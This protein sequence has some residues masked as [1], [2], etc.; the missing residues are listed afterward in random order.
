MV[1]YRWFNSVLSFDRAPYYVTHIR[2]LVAFEEG[3]GGMLYTSLMPEST[4]FFID[5][6]CA[7]ARDILLYL[8]KAM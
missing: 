7:S 6:C 3:G 2:Q 1:P 5:N 8:G 4:P